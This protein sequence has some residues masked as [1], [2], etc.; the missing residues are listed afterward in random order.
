MFALEL[1]YSIWAGI[2]I[3]ITIIIIILRMCVHIEVGG[4][5]WVSTHLDF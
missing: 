5:P 2:I 3:I 1:G 4:Q